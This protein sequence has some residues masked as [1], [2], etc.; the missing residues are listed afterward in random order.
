MLRISALFLLGTTA[1]AVSAGAQTPAPAGTADS[2]AGLVS[3]LQ[4]RGSAKPAS[5]V[6]LDQARKLQQ[7]RNSTA[8]SNSATQIHAAGI[9]VP[10]TL[11]LVATPA[12]DSADRSGG[13]TIKVDQASPRVIVQQ[14]EPQVNVSQAQPEITVR[15]PAP[16]VTIDI[17]QPIVTVKM[18]QPDVNV[19]MQQPVVSVT[20]PKPSVEIVQAAKPQVQVQEA[21][22]NVQVQ[23]AANDQA[24]VQMQPETGKPKIS[25]ESEKAKVVVNQGKGDPQVNV[26]RTGDPASAKPQQQAANAAVPVAAIPLVP[27]V[28]AM[29]AA[30]SASAGQQIS[31]SRLNAMKL[32]NA[33][34]NELG[35]VEHVV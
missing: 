8:C 34:G 9:E 24:N 18:P 16:T 33:R 12:A 4:Q 14:P 30:S 7:D 15:Q 6:S 11:L 10:A 13:A 28:P 29:A 19:S 26:E 27:V 21:Q 17:P 20:Q 31:V 5:P 3:F 25:Y 32:Y 2:C 1:L 22:A 23:R 35:D